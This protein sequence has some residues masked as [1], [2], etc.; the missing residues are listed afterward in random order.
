MKYEE[1]RME[2]VEIELEDVCT[3]SVEDPTKD[4]SI[5]DPSN[6]TGMLG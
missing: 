6:K 4:P 3:M 5:T 2:K 1:P